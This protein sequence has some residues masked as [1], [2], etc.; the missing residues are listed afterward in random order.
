MA[1]VKS[2][3]ACGRNNDEVRSAK[4][5]K[6]NAGSFLR[7]EQALKIAVEI[8]DFILNNAITLKRQRAW[9][10]LTYDPFHDLEQLSLLN[11]DILSGVCGIAIFLA[12]LFL[13]SD[14]RRFG[15]ACLEILHQIASRRTEAEEELSSIP[16]AHS[17][18][19]FL[20]PGC[21]IYTVQRCA[22]A[23]ANS[24]FDKKARSIAISNSSRSSSR[25]VQGA[26]SGNPGL[27]LALT[28]H[29]N[30]GRSPSLKILR[31]FKSVVESLS[32]SQE[33]ARY[34]ESANR[35]YSLPSSASAIRLALTRMEVLA[36]PRRS[37]KKS[38]T[39]SQADCCGRRAELAASRCGD[40]LALIG[41]SELRGEDI[42]S[43]VLSWLEAHSD[44]PS[45]R[46][47]LDLLE[48]A[49]TARRL[50]RSGEIEKKARLYASEL[51]GLRCSTGSWFSDNL[52][53]DQHSLSIVWGLPAIGHALLRLRD[54]HGVKSVRLLE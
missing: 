11:D 16:A 26:I 51:V 22:S 8:G 40:I 54:P 6:Q 43:P 48:I 20:G 32:E 17:L 7:D 37:D 3:L 2:C 34:P 4:A 13:A 19:G 23:L 44:K 38:D 10:G 50:P 36:T 21:Q 31:E 46:Q 47:I 1:I 27:L 28:D 29:L 45:S 30:N 39:A 41:E 25:L 12:D 35:L 5:S 33:E 14:I 42:V 9:I 24:I 18:S 53:A 52:A 15:Q 49:T